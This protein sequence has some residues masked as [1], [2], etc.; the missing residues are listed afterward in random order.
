M[1]D[2]GPMPLKELRVMT[3]RMFSCHLRPEGKRKQK[4]SK[5]WACDLWLNT[6]N[7][8]TL[9]QEVAYTKSVN[10]FLSV[11]K[12]S[13]KTTKLSSFNPDTNTHRNR[14][15]MDGSCAKG[16]LPAN[17]R[18]PWSCLWNIWS[19]TVDASTRSARITHLMPWEPLA[20]NPSAVD[21]NQC[22]VSGD[23]EVDMC[24]VYPDSRL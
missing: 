12:D 10:P 24:I 3:R 7:G 20:A 16:K 1:A 6:S 8:L 9:K 2:S 19:S 13:M 11:A 15:E 4:K 18:S 22:K 5:D 23:S 17:I 14:F 21:I